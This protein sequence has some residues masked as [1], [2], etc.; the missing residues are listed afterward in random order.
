MVQRGPGRHSECGSHQSDD[1][2]VM[3]LAKG[4]CVDG[5]HRSEPSAIVPCFEKLGR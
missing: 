4:T 2:M 5:A 3:E 1:G